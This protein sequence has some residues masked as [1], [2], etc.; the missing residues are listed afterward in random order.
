MTLQP[1]PPE[2]VEQQRL[3]SE[4]ASATNDSLR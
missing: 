3:E 4:I 1:L 2:K